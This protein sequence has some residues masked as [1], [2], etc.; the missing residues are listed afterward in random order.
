MLA[1]LFKFKARILILSESW[2]DKQFCKKFIILLNRI[3][4]ESILQSFKSFNNYPILFYKLL[5]IWF[6][7]F[8]CFHNICNVNQIFDNSKFIL[9][10][11]IVTTVAQTSFLKT[12][13]AS[14]RNVGGFAI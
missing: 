8:G 3:N 11:P 6:F 14:G 7:T 5:K 1:E 2:K 13:I 12:A 4:P 9:P 10:Q